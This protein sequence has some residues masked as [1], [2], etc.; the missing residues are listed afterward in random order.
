M[1]RAVGT[2]MLLLLGGNGG[3]LAARTCPATTAQTV[4]QQDY[5]RPAATP[6]AGGTNYRQQL[7]PGVTA[8]ARV[9]LKWYGWKIA[10]NKK[11]INAAFDACKIVPARRA[12]LMSMAFLETTLLTADQRDGS[13]DGRG[14]PHDDNVSLWNLS[15]DLVMYVGYRDNPWLLNSDPA[16]AACVLNTAFDKFGIQRTLHFVRGGRTAFNDGRSFGAQRFVQVIASIMKAVDANPSLMTDK[17]R[18]EAY[19]EPV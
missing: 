7:L 12:L 10:K 6:A 4:E 3:A 11:V 18:A 5:E 16:K 8:N 14:D 9:D 2:L 1:L 19:L 17:R 15:L 13:K